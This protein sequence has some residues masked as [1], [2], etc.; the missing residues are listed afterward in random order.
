[1][2]DIVAWGDKARSLLS[3]ATEAHNAT[4][5]SRDGLV[6]AGGSL[7]G[8]LLLS[9]A[10]ECALK[11]LLESQGTKITTDLK[12]HGLH[13]LYA[14]VG[15]EIQRR[16]AIVYEQMVGSDRDERLRTAA[17]ATLA[18]CLRNH[19]SSFK[20]WRYDVANAGRFYPFPMICACI[21]MLTLV[22]PKQTFAVGSRTSP[23][24]VV[25]DG[26]AMRKSPD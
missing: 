5:D 13:K 10:A 25:L 21:S 6:R 18:G 26:R 14:K 22:Y 24:I 17:T 7:G 12:I 20:R 15:L 23:R 4:S 11:A 16:A 8:A 2:S 19:D 3:F 1:M 9:F